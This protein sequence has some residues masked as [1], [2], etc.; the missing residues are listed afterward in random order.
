MLSGTKSHNLKEDD[1][2]LENE[3]FAI[4]VNILNKFFYFE[5]GAVLLIELGT[6]I[7]ATQREPCSERSL[8][9][10]LLKLL[11]DEELPVTAFNVKGETMCAP[12]CVLKTQASHLPELCANCVKLKP[13]RINDT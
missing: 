11:N 9:Y 13:M 1:R 12:K 4:P 2:A 10:Q 7:N 8:W 3:C 5:D 6:I